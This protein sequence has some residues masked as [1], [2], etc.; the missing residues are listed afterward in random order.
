MPARSELKIGSFACLYQARK[1]MGW[2][3]RDIFLK[4]VNQSQES[5]QFLEPELF[6]CEKKFKD[7]KVYPTMSS[8]YFYK[9]GAILLLYLRRV[10]SHRMSSPTGVRYSECFYLTIMAR[11]S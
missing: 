4:K 6:L 9:Y 1:Y 2:E 10:F 5:T 8:R 7:R 11:Q 3:S